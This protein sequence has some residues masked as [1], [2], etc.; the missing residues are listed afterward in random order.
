MSIDGVDGL[1]E[2]LARAREYV[3]AL[4]LGR[5]R[6][7]LLHLARGTA[8]EV[9]GLNGPV[10]LPVRVPCFFCVFVTLVRWLHCC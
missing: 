9:R 4:P 5:L 7:A 8:M 6:D 2:E 3:D 10:C 1:G